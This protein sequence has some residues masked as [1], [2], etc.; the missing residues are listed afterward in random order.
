MAQGSGW[1]LLQLFRDRRALRMRPARSERKTPATNLIPFGA[2]VIGKYDLAYSIRARQKRPPKLLQKN[3]VALNRARPVECRAGVW[4]LAKRADSAIA[5]EAPDQK[6]RG[7]PNGVLPRSTS[8][9]A[10][11]R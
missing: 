1:K 8:T 2:I 5:K 3:L 6:G 4:F 9:A 7:P 11:Q 10:K